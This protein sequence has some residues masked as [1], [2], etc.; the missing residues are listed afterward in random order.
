MKG[1]IIAYF[2]EGRRLEA[3]PDPLIESGPLP[4]AP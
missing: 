2:Q 3:M 1:T 4:F